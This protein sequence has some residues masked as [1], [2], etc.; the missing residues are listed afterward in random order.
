M[1]ERIAA[2]AAM[3]S[4]AGC[5]GGDVTE[6][7]SVSTDGEKLFAHCSACHNVDKPAHNGIGPS[8]RGVVG[9]AVGRQPDFAYSGAMKSAG[10]VWDEARL[11]AYIEQPSKTV[12]G[13]RMMFAGIS[14][15]RQRKLLID[16][17]RSND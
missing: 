7:A 14:D 10:G 15:A 5:S 11:D 13:N 9:R 16:Y 8:L 17:L 3:L 12:P 2:C 1:I 6:N 4:I